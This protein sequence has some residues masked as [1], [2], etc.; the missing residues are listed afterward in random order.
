M[1]Q[2]ALWQWDDLIAA[3]DGKAGCGPRVAITG[4]SIDTRTLHPG[5]V[6]VA[7]RDA[8]DG[9]DFVGAAFKS[10]APAALVAEGYSRQPEDGALIRVDDP[11]TAL[12]R[13]GIAARARL[14][15]EARVIAVTGSVGKTGTKEMLRAC[16]ARLGRTHAADKSFNNHWGVPLTLARMPADTRYAVF[17]IGMSHA[18]EITPLVQMVRPHVAIITAVE[19]VHL[20]HFSSESAIADAKAE[21]L[22]GLV[23][24]GT[25]ILNADNRHFGRLAGRAEA[26]GARIVTFGRDGAADVRAETWHLRSDGT[27]VTVVVR[28]RRIEYAL[29]APGAHIAQNSLAVV[30]ALDAIGADLDE[31]L[32]ALAGLS[33]PQ[34]RGARIELGVAGGTALLIDES[35]NANPA[36]MRAALA[37]MASV[38]RERFSRRIAVIGD[39]LELGS[40]AAEMHRSLKADI[41]AAG[42]DL[43]FGCGPHTRLLV[44]AIEPGRCG[45]W[46]ASSDGIRDALIQAVRAGDVIMIKG[47]LGSRMGPLVAALKERYRSAQ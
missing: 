45:L 24:G 46:S 40:S 18:G 34:G 25:A 6:F 36:S 44:D 23:P 10:G 3:A 20:E 9:H 21:I 28:G 39:M 38:P 11:L 4:F 33:A 32:P 29:G 30:A 31:A 37:A 7:L 2:D 43:L 13:I 19:P 17:E 27:D 41:D 12:E 47:S 15:D 35:Y 1:R 5:E 26:T 22:A 16:C 14:M 8:R 42:I